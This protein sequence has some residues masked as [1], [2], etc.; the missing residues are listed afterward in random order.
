LATVFNGKTKEDDPKEKKQ[1]KEANKRQ[2]GS[3]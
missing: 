3:F 1:M 2:K